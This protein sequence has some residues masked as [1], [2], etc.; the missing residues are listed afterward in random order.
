M[1]YE[2]VQNPQ[3]LTGLGFSLKPP[4]WL[5]N[6]IQQGVQ[7]VEGSIQ[8]AVSNAADSASKAITKATTPATPSPVDQVNSAVANIPGGWLTIAGVGAGLLLLLRRKG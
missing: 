2:R 3:Q 4:A 7:Q 8:K 1:P 6:Q 5:R